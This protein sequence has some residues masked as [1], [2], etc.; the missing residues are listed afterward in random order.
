MIYEK[1]DNVGAQHSKY[2]KAHKEREMYE[3]CIEG[4]LELREH[5]KQY[6]PQ[7]PAEDDDSYKFRINTLTHF[8]L[9][10]KTRDVMTG[11]VFKSEIDLGEDVSPQIVSLT[12]N[13]DNSG[14][15]VDVFARKAMEERFAGYAVILAD[16]PSANV[17]TLEEQRALNLRPFLKL[18][19]ADSIW[20]WD[21]EIYRNK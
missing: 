20:N 10:K 6:I 17:Q 21:W 2:A 19:K 9:T 5:A 18:Y 4:T 7:F 12:E 3:A 1:Q 13:I 14:T 11:L 8:N 16:S 15:H